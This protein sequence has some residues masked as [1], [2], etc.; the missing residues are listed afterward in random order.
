M[1]EDE[2]ELSDE[3]SLEI[4]DAVKI[5]A[6]FAAELKLQ[7]TPR[8]FERLIQYVHFVRQPNINVDGDRGTE[9]VNDIQ[10]NGK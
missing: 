7:L 8:N 4:L 9:C 2:L 6:V 3:F 10:V 1:F 5:V